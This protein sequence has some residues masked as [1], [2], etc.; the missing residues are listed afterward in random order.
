MPST[1][2]LVKHDVSGVSTA[3]SHFTQAY[4]AAPAPPK[5]GGGADIFSTAL[6]GLDVAFD[7]QLAVAD[8][9]L[10]SETVGIVGKNHASTGI[11]L[12]ADGENAG[13]MDSVVEA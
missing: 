5:L 1:D 10:N 11:L 9:K 12:G 13:S 2:G 3:N 6:A 4:A 8:A 7:P